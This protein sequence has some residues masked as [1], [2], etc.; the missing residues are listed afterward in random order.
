MANQDLKQEVVCSG[1]NYQS[2]DDSPISFARTEDND[3]VNHI[4]YYNVLPGIDIV[5]NSFKSKETLERQYI[6]DSKT[7]IEIN[8]CMEGRFYCILDGK[9]TNLGEGEIDAHFGGLSKREAEFPLGWYKGITLI[10]AL[11]EFSNGIQ[12]LFPEI[13]IQ[14]DILLSRMKQ[15]NGIVKIKATKEL[16]ELFHRLYREQPA[17]K[18][19]YLRLKV[20]EILA[21]MQT[22]SAGDCMPK[23]Y[24]RKRDLEIV[25][26][27]YNEVVAHLDKRYSLQELAERYGIGRTTLQRCFKEIYGQ[28]Y[29]SFLKQY[30]MKQAVCLLQQGDKS[31]TEIAGKLGY[32]NVSKFASAFCSIYGYNP[33]EYKK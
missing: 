33:K 23:K 32:G 13:N 3:S 2:K 10:I 22:M 11:E 26:E 31:I 16:L 1:C 14:L 9:A 21:H 12:T 15:H 28:P 19:F 30:R 5:Y 25:K 7:V 29:Y 4:V 6:T 18:E 17:M 24:F 27:I 8:F 20:L